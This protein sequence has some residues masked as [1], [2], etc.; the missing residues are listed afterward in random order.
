MATDLA[1][2]SSGNTY[3][4]GVA[5]HQSATHYILWYSAG[6]TTV[7][8]NVVR[9]GG[10]WSAF[11]SKVDSSGVFQWGAYAPSSSRA[12]YPSTITLDLSGNPIMCGAFQG[13][14]LT[15]YTSADISF[16]T[17][18]NSNSWAG[19]LIKYTTTGGG[20]SVTTYAA[21]NNLLQ[22]DSALTDSSG[23]IFISGK[24]SIGS[25][26]RCFLRKYDSSFVVQWTASQ[27]S[28]TAGA[29]AGVTQIRLDSAGNII[30]VGDFQSTSITVQNA[31]GSVFSV[32]TNTPEN[33]ALVDYR[34]IF[35]V[36]YNTSGVAQWTQR[37]GGER[38]DFP[39]GL[40]IDT[41]NNIH[42]YAMYRSTNFAI[43][44]VNGTIVDRLTSSGTVGEVT[45]ASNILLAKL[46]SAGT[47]I[48]RNNMIISYDTKFLTSAGTEITGVDIATEKG[49]QYGLQGTRK[50][51]FLQNDWY[52]S[53][54]VGNNNIISF[55]PI[56]TNFTFTASLLVEYAYLGEEELKW[57]KKSRHNFLLE[58]KQVL[59][60]AL[61]TG[62]TALPLQFVGPVTDLWVTARTD[63]NLNTYTYSN[64][65][66]MALTLNTC[67]MFNYNGVMFNLLA[68]FEVADNFPT[69]NVF[70]YRFG[71]PTNFS[72][73]RDKVLTVEM[74]QP[75]NIQVW[76]RT[77]N[78]LVV[79][80]GMG[81][82]LFNS[83]T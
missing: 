74:S 33:V 76:A 62:K 38:D 4:C 50:Y 43:T 58:Q 42:L 1:I 69:R 81:G 22:I 70:M 20:T 73:I 68:P 71:A 30:M 77:F 41:S 54:V 24:E 55:D 35:I 9:G 23:N 5:G 15:A 12:A 49:F 16:G 72:R 17:A 67:E 27:I 52:N 39:G 36:K 31:D 79:Q 29:Y 21:T 51:F 34:D 46:N 47:L 7:Q 59:K 10:G 45:G 53:G 78:V 25:T 8:K 63:A 40:D 19:F 56:S 82:L 65:T 61:T 57:F 75:V 44:N 14:T 28:G 6:G 2:D 66:S 3:F 37:W 11:I 64:I 80:N 32:L 60:T 13:S 26:Y 83:Y 48:W 18:S